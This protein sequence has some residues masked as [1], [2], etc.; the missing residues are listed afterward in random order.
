MRNIV[1]RCS[2]V[3]VL[4][5][6]GVNMFRGLA[7]LGIVAAVGFMLFAASG[8]ASKTTGSML[9]TETEGSNYQPGWVS[10]DC[11]AFWGD[12]LK[13]RLCGTGSFSGSGDVATLRAKAIEEARKKVSEELESRVQ[14]VV[15]HYGKSHH[16]HKD[17]GNP[18]NLKLMK[19]T[20]QNITKDA[21]QMSEINDF[22][23]TSQNEVYALV[24]LTATAFDDALGRMSRLSEELRKEMHKR[25]EKTITQA[26]KDL[27]KELDKEAQELLEKE[28]AGK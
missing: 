4:W 12:N 11:A 25:A 20:S 1:L 10:G 2:S 6:Y 16:G 21:M 7:R 27:R 23:I 18:P 17:F 5:C 19:E 28:E 15:E 14:A 8:C 3:R 26:E 24:S 22:W 9:I 13:D